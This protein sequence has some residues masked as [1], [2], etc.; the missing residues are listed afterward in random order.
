MSKEDK[1]TVKEKYE[2]IIRARNFHYENFNKWLTYFYVAIGSLFIGY[3]T[4]I[5]A[6]L[7]P[8]N[9]NLLEYLI[10][11][12][13][14]LVSLFWYWSSKGYYYWNINF[15]TLVNHYEREILKLPKNERLYSAFA[16][17]KVQ[18]NFFN[19]IS[20][21]NI[22]TSKVAILFAFLITNV[23]G[24]LILS[25]IYSPFKCEYTFLIIAGEVAISIGAIMFFSLIIAKPFLKSNLDSL[26]DLKI[27]QD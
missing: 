1:P 17:K 2:I 27:T 18:N 12:L 10:L 19:P 24:F 7:E 21:A 16:N 9:Q 14:F 25:K 11:G 3:C 4:I 13:G 15:I 6:K 20:G 26:S 5:S 23:W 22:S 8:N